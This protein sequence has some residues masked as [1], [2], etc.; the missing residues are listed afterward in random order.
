MYMTYP[1]GA[2]MQ[3]GA[4]NYWLAV[5]MLIAILIEVVWWPLPR[6]FGFLAGQYGEDGK[7][8]L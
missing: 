5:R 1:R 2:E 7:D 8:G 3:I 4:G 6:G